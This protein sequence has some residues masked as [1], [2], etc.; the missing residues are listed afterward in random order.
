MKPFEPANPIP[1]PE[2]PGPALAK[3]ISLARSGAVNEARQRFR[4]ILEERPQCVEALVWSG[5]LAEDPRDGLARISEAAQLDPN[6]SWV[7]AALVWARGRVPASDSS[8]ARAAPALGPI[9]RGRRQSAAVRW[10]GIG[11]FAVLVVLAG[12]VAAAETD[13]PRNLWAVLFPTATPTIT[14]TPT[15]TATHTNTPLPTATHTNTPSPT[16]TPTH[17][18]TPTP[19]NTA[20]TTPSPTFTA[21]YTPWPQSPKPSATPVPPTRVPA[22]AAPAVPAANPG[23]SG[24]W[25]DVNLTTQRLV[26]Y[27]GNTA[28]FST[29][30]ST[31]L[32]RTPTVTGRFN[33]YVKY[34]S[35]PMSGPG[36]YLPN[37]PYVMYFY[38]GYS[39]HG[40][41]WHNNFGHP[42]SHGCVNLRT[43]DAAWVFNWS[44]PAVPAG[45]NSASATASNPGTLVVIHY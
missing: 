5:V 26:A 45:S 12:T 29:V 43:S 9:S 17:T 11:A 10:F 42:M 27:Q 38:A 20:T 44:G 1:D 15:P 36:Y 13:A 8:P 28:V 4:M 18:S 23:S 33:I 31:G 39:L 3:A 35:A 6:G 14:R 19:T 34:R 37:V 40:T 7:Q 25:I 30:V 32:P 2:S 16:A 21:T 22:K 41:Y 24:K